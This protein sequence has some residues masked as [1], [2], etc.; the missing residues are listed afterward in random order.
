MLQVIFS[1]ESFKRP[2]QP[3]PVLFHPDS[4]HFPTAGL[5]GEA[6]LPVEPPLAL[7]RWY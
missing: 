5:A 4:I 7:V 3:C 2:R 1:M 6:I